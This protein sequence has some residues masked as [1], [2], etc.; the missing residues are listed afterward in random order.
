MESGTIAWLEAS[1]GFADPSSLPREFMITA[2]SDA[3]MRMIENVVVH[4]AKRAKIK[5]A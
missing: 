5:A 1:P 3:G 2:E 4:L